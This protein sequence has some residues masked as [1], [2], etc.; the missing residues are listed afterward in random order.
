MSLS[1]VPLAFSRQI[2][3]AVQAGDIAAMY[4]ALACTA[5]QWLLACGRSIELRDRLTRAE[6]LGRNDATGGLLA[7]A[8]DLIDVLELSPQG[9]EALANLRR[10]PVPQETEGE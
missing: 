7:A 3:L 6:C 5:A 8:L 9:R 10:Q 2:A 1:P 4:R